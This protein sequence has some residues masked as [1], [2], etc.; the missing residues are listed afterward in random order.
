MKIIVSTLNSKF[1]H[2]SLSIRLI[3]NWLT[4]HGHDSTWL[5]YTINSP[6]YP[7]VGALY[8]EQAD[9]YI[10]SL[11]IWNGDLMRQIASELKSLMPNVKIA[12]GGPEV[13][14]DS[15]LELERSPY[16]D[17]IVRNEGEIATEALVR[18]IKEKSDLSHVEGLT[19]RN[20]DK[21]VSNKPSEPVAMDE[22]EFP[23]PDVANLKDRILY[24]ES[25]RG[26]PYNCSYCLSSTFKGIRFKSI[27]LVKQDIKQFMGASVR[28]VKWI[29]R[30]FNADPKRALEIWQYLASEDD[31]H[32]NHH[33]EITAEL[34]RDEDLAFLSEVRKGLFQFEI[35][36]QTTMPEASEAVNRRLSFDKL[37]KPVYEL[38]KNENIHVHLDLIAGLP[39]EGYDRFLQSFDDVYGLKPQVLQLGFLKLIK[40]SGLR[41]QSDIFAYVSQSAAPYEVMANRFISFDEMLRLKDMEEVVEHLHNSKRF[42]KSLKYLLEMDSRPSIAFTKFADWLRINGHFDEAIK[43]EKWYALL[44]DYFNEQSKPKEETKKLFVFA[45]MMDYM[46]T[47]GKQA[48]TWLNDLAAATDG[49]AE[50]F[51]IAKTEAFE[52]IY[53][54]LGN[55]SPKERI[56]KIRYVGLKGINATT[57]TENGD[58][59]G[60]KIHKEIVALSESDCMIIVDLNDRHPVTERYKIDLFLKE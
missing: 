55:L 26:C 12:F 54:T 2:T 46:A 58:D 20:A 52:N 13:S 48:P 56:K 23:Y 60:V 59:R 44:W 39:Y 47:T 37:A 15:P 35:G 4:R 29:D 5:E 24:Y 10:F 28:Q 43:G 27:D 22:I 38:Q 19:W 34:L 25:S 57:V 50:V 18:A 8:K 21:I 36:V 45:L 53:P 32:I 9:L 41:N 14:F 49:K 7:I 33:F 42:I 3:S 17:F 1:T 31:G 6:I 40:G 51:E 30:T 16:V 11:Y